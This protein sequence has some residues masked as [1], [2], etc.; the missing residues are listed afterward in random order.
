MLGDNKCPCGS[1]IWL[2]I[3]GLLVLARHQIRRPSLACF[4]IEPGHLASH[5]LI[6][7]VTCF[8]V[9]RLSSPH[10]Q[11]ISV[12]WEGLNILWLELDTTSEITTSRI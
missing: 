11:C 2:G 3:L 6:I 10:Q 12:S 8:A 1:Q 5:A 4:R 7:V 9:P